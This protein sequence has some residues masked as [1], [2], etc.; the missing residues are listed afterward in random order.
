MP[1]NSALTS[2]KFSI[3]FSSNAVTRPLQHA[4]HILKSRSRARFA[5]IAGL[6]FALTLPALGVVDSKVLMASGLS[7]VRS[8]EGLFARCET[9]LRNMDVMGLFATGGV[10]VLALA[11]MAGAG[12]LRARYKE[13]RNLTAD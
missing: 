10:A 3:S 2:Q 7:D 1:T 11:A 12:Y 13:A 6:S 4:L 8:V 9:A 5:A